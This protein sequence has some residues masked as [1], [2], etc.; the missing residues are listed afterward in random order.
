MNHPTPRILLIGG[1]QMARALIGGWL[2]SGYDPK[3]IHV[4]DHNASSRDW[5]SSHFQAIHIYAEL[6]DAIPKPEVCVLCVKPQGT[7]KTC[8]PLNLWLK[9]SQ[10]LIISVIAGVRIQ[11]LVQ[12]LN[13]PRMARTMPNRPALKGAGIT[14]VCTQGLSVD[15]IQS[16]CELM[17][18]VGK[19]VRVG[20]D[21]DIDSVT[22]VSGSGP[23]YFFYWMEQLE[24]AALRCG[25]DTH[26][27]RQLA[28]QTALGAAVM[29]QDPHTSPEQLR[30]EVT[31]PKGTTEAALR[32]FNDGGMNEL[33][34]KA[35]KAAKA[36]AA[37][38]ADLADNHSP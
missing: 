12:L 6:G 21:E 31:S 14:A 38:L 17:S 13:Q 22:A 15:D 8:Q 32:V 5:L 23:A 16:T 7:V 29:A 27:A 9:P 36:R 25:L 34:E 19:V 24:K 35:V 2:N 1:G 30:Q 10:P 18:A 37:E 33:I 4:I 3:Q 20:R 11:R 26:T 28:R